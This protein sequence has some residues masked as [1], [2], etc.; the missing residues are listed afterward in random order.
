MPRNQKKADELTIQLLKIERNIQLEKDH[1]AQL[2]ARREL[3]VRELL[4]HYPEAYNRE[5]V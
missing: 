5:D 1:L 2:E 3:L 4:G